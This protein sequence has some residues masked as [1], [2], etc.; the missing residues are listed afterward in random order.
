MTESATRSIPLDRLELSPDNIRKTA[1]D[2]TAERELYASVHAHGLIV[3]LAVREVEP[4][5]GS[6]PAEAPGSSPGEDRVARHAVVDGGRRLAA[7]R[8]LVAQGRIAADAPIPCHI[9]ETDTPDIEV[10]LAA[11]VVRAAMHPI[12]QVEAFGRLA[13]EGATVAGIAARFGV[14]E[15]TVL[16]R[17]RLSNVAPVLLQAY[18]DGEI[19]M[20]TL[21]AFAVT[22]DRERQIAAWNDV[23]AGAYRPSAWRVRSLLT[24]GRVPGN[25]AVAL[26]VGAEAYEAAGGAVDRDLFCGE[27]DAGLWFHDPHL[28]RKLALE[29]LQETVDELAPEWKWTDAIVEADWQALAHYGRVYPEP[30]EPT[31]E[32][33]AEIDRLAI[34]IDEL[35]DLPEDDL[36]DE[37]VA[38]YEAADARHRELHAAAEARASWRAEDRAIAGAIVAIDDRGQVKVVPGLVRPEDI[39]ATEPRTD[40]AGVSDTGDDRT[41]PA[42]AVQPPAIASRPAAPDPFKDAGIGLALAD[43]LRHIR[44][45][46]VQ[47]ELAGNFAA[48][49]DLATFQIAREVLALGY[50]IDPLSIRVVPTPLRPNSRAAD[51]RFPAWSPGE[52]T[53]QTRRTDLATDWL[54]AKDDAEAFAAFRKLPEKA[55]RSLFAFCVARTLTPRLSLD[56]SAPPEYEATVA[57]LGIDF[58]AHVRPTAEGFFSRIPKAKTLEIARNVLGRPWTSGRAGLKKQQLAREMEAA[59]AAGDAIPSDLTAET[60]AAALAWLPPGFRPFH[61]GAPPIQETVATETVGDVGEAGEEDTPAPDNADPDG[62]VAEPPPA[63]AEADPSDTPQPSE[64]GAIDALNRVPTADGSPRVVVIDMRDGA[65]PAESVDESTPPDETS[66]AATAE[67]PDGSDEDD[68]PLP[69]FL[70]RTG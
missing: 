31:E 40:D 7:L 23:G 39:P 52:T 36:T 35:V 59:F 17:L 29:K 32:E 54:E 18:R 5:P 6:G 12:D 9:V 55:K 57:R 70:R 44:G 69:A 51:T 60:R 15:R 62:T 27:H 49:F 64:T 58:A 10:S 45:A 46:I 2:H 66:N 1:P 56:R 53:I 24:E 30:G 4:D 14:P 21:Q 25:A 11:N 26:F 3:P 41:A 34:R 42:P 65:P 63:E 61:T 16:Q 47:A 48:S 33:R 13:T 19:D 43:D 8:E 28:L 37:T 67:E 38:E 20:T 50:R 22:T 68:N